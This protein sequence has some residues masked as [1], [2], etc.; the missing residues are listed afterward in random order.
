M[1]L[2]TLWF[3]SFTYRFP[4]I[5]FV[6][7]LYHVNEF[8]VQYERVKLLKHSHVSLYPLSLILIYLSLFVPDTHRR[9]IPPP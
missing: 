2:E 8:R 7:S 3:H 4:F 6:E 5:A 9:R 1:R